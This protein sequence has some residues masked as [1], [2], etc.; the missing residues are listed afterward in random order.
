ME[1]ILL[2]TMVRH[3]KIKVVLGESQHSFTKGKSY[4]MNIVAFFNK[5]TVLVD[6]GRATDVIYLDLCR[7]LDAVPHNI[8]VST[9]DT[10]GLMDGP[11]GG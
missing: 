9:L 5:V 11:L 2:E 3:V 10:H 8:F 1:W 4:L 7:A 6:K